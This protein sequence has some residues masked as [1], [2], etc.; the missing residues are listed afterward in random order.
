MA[1]CFVVFFRVLTPNGM[2]SASTAA[3]SADQSSVLADSPV[4]LLASWRDVV[5]GE[6][7]LNCWNTVTPGTWECSGVR[8]SLST[9]PISSSWLGKFLTF[10]SNT[11]QPGVRE[12][13][14]IAH[15]VHII[16]D[17]AKK[18]QGPTT[19][20][21]HCCSSASTGWTNAPVPSSLYL[22]SFPNNH[23]H[24]RPH[25]DWFRAVRCRKC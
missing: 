19:T 6:M 4:Q 5:E 8:I 14:T 24:L 7:L 25:V 20:S 15:V 9:A 13:S 1:C 12:G 3:G 18:K 2:L 10:G 21:S 16:N 23:N 11:H 17:V 22:S